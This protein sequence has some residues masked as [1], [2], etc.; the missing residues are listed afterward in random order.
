M[1][2]FKSFLNEDVENLNNLAPEEVARRIAKECSEFIKESGFHIETS[3]SARTQSSPYRMRNVLY[4]GSYSVLRD[5]TVIKFRGNKER[6][7][8]DSSRQ[9]HELLDEF[10]ESNF[11]FP[12][13]SKGTFT[14]NAEATANSYGGVRIFFPKNGYSY[15][16]SEIIFDAYVAFQNTNINSFVPG[17]ADMFN[18][19]VDDMHHEMTE[20]YEELGA[21]DDYSYDKF[22][23]DFE[24]GRLPLSQEIWF[25]IV[26]KWLNANKRKLYKDSGLSEIVQARGNS[27]TEIM[28]KCD[29]YYLVSMARLGNE[30]DYSKRF[31][32]ELSKHI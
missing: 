6:V 22:L 29:E 8:K 15:V 23:K 16:Y 21:D 17:N 20:I 4:R 28:F 27:G 31:M 24:D 3:S 13:R 11:G 12:Y 14:T 30:P 32:D 19:V 9:L 10:L 26:D 5:S 2:T 7:P 18:E 25:E 1:I